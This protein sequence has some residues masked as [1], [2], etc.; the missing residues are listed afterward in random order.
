MPKQEPGTNTNVNISGNSEESSG[1]RKMS[2]VPSEWITVVK[3]MTKATALR[4][5]QDAAALRQ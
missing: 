1:I 4:P 5:Q 3:K 2:Q